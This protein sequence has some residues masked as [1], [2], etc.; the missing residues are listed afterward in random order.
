M[1]AGIA[2][3]SPRWPIQMG[4]GIAAG[5]HCRRC[6]HSG[7]PAPE[8]TASFRRSLPFGSRPFERY[9]S[10]PLRRPVPPASRRFLVR[11]AF[12]P[13]ASAV[14]DHMG[15][16]VVGA[17]T[18]FCA[19]PRVLPLRACFLP[20]PLG[21]APSGS[22][23]RPRHRTILPSGRKGPFRAVW[24]V[25]PCFR[26]C[27]VL[28]PVLRPSALPHQLCFEPPFRPPEPVFPVCPPPVP[29]RASAR[30]NWFQ[31]ILFSPARSGIFYFLI[32]ALRR[33]SQSLV[34]SRQGRCC[35]SPVSR[36]SS[37]MQSYP[38]AA[39]C[40]VDNSASCG[41]CNVLVL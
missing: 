16:A 15:L 34:P 7:I 23:S 27:R 37:K 21:D 1:G 30:W 39:Q 2:A 25:A 17:R 41:F 20:C 38:Q 40:Q 19:L 10:S 36:T 12:S 35:A 4:A 13:A 11:S 24:R 3:G 32:S 31:N 8:L 28:P 26:V 18:T 33:F 9:S 5:P 6:W 22:A 29:E 14:P